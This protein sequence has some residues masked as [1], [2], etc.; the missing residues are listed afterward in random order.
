MQPGDII[1]SLGPWAASR[2]IAWATRYTNEPGFSHASIALDAETILQAVPP[3]VTTIS[4]ADYCQYNPH[5]TILSPT[6]ATDAQRITLVQ[7]ALKTKG[8][9]YGI[10]KYVPLGLDTLFHTYKFSRALSFLKGDPVCSLMVADVYRTLN[11]TFARYKF[12]VRPS[13]MYHYAMTH[14]GKYFITKVK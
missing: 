3:V 13:D 8:E 12:A 9:L 5:V 4:Y 11:W 1:L 14:L 2:F 10:L 6:E 7:E